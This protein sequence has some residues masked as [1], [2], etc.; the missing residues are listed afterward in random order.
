M[1]H[2]ERLSDGDKGGGPG[3]ILN[4]DPLSFQGSETGT[5]VIVS[6][7]SP[8]PVFYRVFEDVL[9][10]TPQGLTLIQSPGGSCGAERFG[11]GISPGQVITCTFTNEYRVAPT[12]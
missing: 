12:P 1:S 7:F 5:L 6:F 11:Q 9:P 8:F 4:L 10:P 2:C 3:T